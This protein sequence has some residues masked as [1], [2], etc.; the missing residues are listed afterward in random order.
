MAC[1]ICGSTGPHQTHR[2]REMMYGS[3]EWFDYIECSDCGCLQIADIPADL[4]RH[5]RDDYYSYR[6]LTPQR[7]GVKAR[8]TR[9]RDRYALTRKGMAGRLLNTAYPTREFALYKPIR[10]RTHSRVMDVGCGGG[11]LLDRMA[12]SGLTQLV[13]VDPFVQA[14]THTALGIP[15]L[16]RSLGDMSGAYDLIMFHHSFEH[17]PDQHETLQQAARLL[18]PGGCCMVRIPTVSSLAWQHYG[19][20]WVQLDAP[21]HL[22]L[23]S[24]DSLKRLADRAGLQLRKITYDSTAFQFWGSEQYR[25]GIPLRS[26]HSYAEHP[27]KA[28]FSPQ[29]MARWQQQAD[30]L[31]HENQGDQATFYLFR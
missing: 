28:P 18:A 29:D 4:G 27:D 15:I 26:E 6:D 12:A 9:M 21:R 1:R 22:Y 16:K 14:D 10:L 2:A 31:N 3:N 30:T 17:I 20:D 11:H 7:S 8:L 23:H 5:Y 24:V 13:G 25:Q 19:A